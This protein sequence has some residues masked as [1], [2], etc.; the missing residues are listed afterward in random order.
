MGPV[1]S[2]NCALRGSRNFRRCLLLAVIFDGAA[3]QRKVENKKYFRVG[4][5]DFK[6]QH[7][8]AICFSILSPMACFHVIIDFPFLRVL[9][10]MEIVFHSCFN[11]GSVILDGP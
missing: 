8:I 11:V 4:P 10:G 5:N 6:V 3:F 9:L 7:F 1:I 2:V